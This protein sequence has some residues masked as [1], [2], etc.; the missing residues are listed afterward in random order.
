MIEVTPGG[1]V[2]LQGAS[3]KPRGPQKNAQLKLT[4]GVSRCLIGQVQAARI[5]SVSGQVNRAMP[6]LRQQTRN[7][8][9]CQEN[10]SQH[11]P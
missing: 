4:V 10:Q 6:F 8:R 11:F 3:S 2:S 5:L 1:L 9:L 7:L